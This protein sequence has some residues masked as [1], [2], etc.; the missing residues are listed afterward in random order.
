MGPFSDTSCRLV[1]WSECFDAKDQEGLGF[2]ER[3][4]RNGQG[5]EAGTHDGFRMLYQFKV[6]GSDLMWAPL[7]A[8]VVEGAEW[9]VLRLLDR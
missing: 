6:A 3:I 7:R 4:H 2:L 9:R 8:F 1:L 5:S